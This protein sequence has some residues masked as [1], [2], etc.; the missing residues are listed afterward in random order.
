MSISK[1]V[2]NAIDKMDMVT[3]SQL[4]ALINERKTEIA[5]EVKNTLKVG[6]E[7]KVNHKKLAGYKCT[8]TAIRL[9]RVTVKASYGMSYNVPMTMIEP[10]KLSKA[11]M[12]RREELMEACAYTF[13]KWG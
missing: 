7:V 4:Q 6:D 10:V 8:I 3:L 5:Y 13:T 11:E 9:K 12:K 1:T 2:M